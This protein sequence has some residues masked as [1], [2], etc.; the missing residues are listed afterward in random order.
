MKRLPYPLNILNAIYGHNPSYYEKY[1][2]LGTEKLDGIFSYIVSQ[3]YFSKQ[4]KEIFDLYYRQGHTMKEIEEITGLSKQSI[5]VKTDTVLQKIRNYPRLTEF[6]NDYPPVR[7]VWKNEVPNDGNTPIENCE[8]SPLTYNALKRYGIGTLGDLMTYTAQEICLIRCIGA[9][10][11]AAIKEALSSIG[12]KT[13]D[14]DEVLLT[15]T[16]IHGRNKCK[17]ST[18]NKTENKYAK[19]ERKEECM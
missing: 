1:K 9:E 10:G 19:R 13:T 7:A 8:F 18:E 12:C 15:V 2:K 3:P 17:I 16:A 4:N 11:L 6:L 14:Y 5:T